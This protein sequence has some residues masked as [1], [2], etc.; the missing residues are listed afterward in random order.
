M[1]PLQMQ[2]VITLLSHWDHDDNTC[3]T[4]LNEISLRKNAWKYMKKD[5]KDT[6]E[7]EKCM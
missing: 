4:T 3:Y 6:K 1:H 2:T 5:V 7:P